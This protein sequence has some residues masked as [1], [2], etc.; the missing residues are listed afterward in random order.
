M[1]KVTLLSDSIAR[2]TALRTYD[3][4][5]QWYA[6]QCKPL[7]EWQVASTLAKLLDLTVYLPEYRHYVDGQ[8]QRMPLFPRYLFVKADL[9][10]IPQSRINATP[11]VL[12]IVAFDSVPQAI[13]EAVIEAVRQ[14][15]DR[16]N[17]QAV[18]SPK[19]FRPGDPVRVVDGPLQSLE[20]VFL[21]RIPPRARARI[22][23][24]FLGRLHELEVN[25]QL[26]DRAVGVTQPKRQRTTR[27][28]GRKI[29]K[30]E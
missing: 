30:H 9:F 19:S 20:A 28:R 27:G 5:G 3:T 2:S 6:V 21:A 16:L 29:R 10:A 26:L 18:V 24:E 1:N 15:A 4:A 12:R 8:I 25:V 14:E 11:G 23:L 13:P 22:L 17:A 7:K